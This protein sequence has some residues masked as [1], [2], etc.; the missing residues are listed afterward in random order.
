MTPGSLPRPPQV[1]AVGGG[2]GLARALSALRLLGNEPTAVI[3]V[4]DDG[5]S[6]GRLRADLGIIALGDLRRALLTLA[7]NRE[8]A[9]VMAHRFHRGQLQGHALGNL[10]LLALAERSGMD[11][12]TAL[13]VAGH[14]LGC[15]GR[16]LPSTTEPVRL[17]ATVAGRE[18][19]GQARVTKAIGRVERVWLE[20]AS[21]RACSEAV[22]AMA[23]AD[24]VVL[25][26]GSLFTSIIA[27][28]L[29]PGLRT[30]LTTSAAR[31]VYVGNLLTQPGETAGLDAPAHVRA[32]LDHVP[33]LALHAVILHEGPPPAGPGEPI[34]GDLNGAALSLGTRVIRADLAAR[35]PDGS[36][37]AGH[38][39]E[40]LARALGAIV[41]DTARDTAPDN[42]ATPPARPD[43]ASV[44]P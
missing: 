19:S 15:A 2:H 38:D 22:A 17:M 20:P 33:G 21:P 3:T 13:T 5:G 28:L 42:H 36:V 25:G 44:A 32:L 1:V 31:V 34:V 12:V 39:P 14:L 23:D 40:R 27:A 18:V 26:P 24:I 4:A 41:R 29:V 9:G 16:V 30:A 7:R 37:G 6:S 11:F 8:L 35:E 10:M 43:D